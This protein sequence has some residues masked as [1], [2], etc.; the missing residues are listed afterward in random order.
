MITAS[1]F[2]QWCQVFGIPTGGGSGGGVTADQV[3]R[4]AFNYAPSMGV[5][6][7]FVVNLSP[8]VAAL[9]DGL[10]V[11]MSSGSLQNST[12]S[13][14][15]KVNSLPA[16]PITLWAGD[17]APGD[18]E[19][20]GSYLFIYNE[21]ANSFQLIN[22]S[23]TTADAFLVQANA[24]NNAI[25]NG[26]PNA[27]NVTLVL[28]PQGTIGLG[29]SIYMQ[30]GAGNDNTGA[31]TLSVN[32]EVNPIFLQDGSQLTAGA[33]VSNGLA[34]LIYSAELD[35]W[36]LMNPANAGDGYVQSVSGTA[37]Q[38]IIDNTDPQNPVASTPQDID[39]DSDVTFNTLRLDGDGLYDANG[40][41]IF[42]LAPVADAVNSMSVY[43]AATGFPPQMVSAGP[44]VDI[45]MYLVAKGNKPVTVFGGAGGTLPFVILSGTGYQHITNFLFA[46]TAQTRNITFPD[47]S[48][49]VAFTDDIPVPGLTWVPVS[50]T[51]QACAVNTGYISNNAALTTFTAPATAPVGSEIVVKGVGAG[52]WTMTANTGQTIR[53]G[54]VVTS[55]GGTVTSQNGTDSFKM[56][57]IVANTTWSIDYAVSAGLSIV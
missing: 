31:S 52:G 9:T 22:P 3:Q 36:V 5:N 16:L 49:T 32:G 26:A 23:L 25:D 10:I 33:L 35:G 43:N 29:F 38:I 45:A 53:L 13:P 2:I 1:E 30:V 4:F 41:L 6:D 39:T 47:K 12:T 27:Y 44:D 34:Y 17:L 40:K 48:G 46:N 8:P 14:T 57:C 51:S 19:P 50:G 21:D 37:K 11:S 15:L 42:L 54:N 20:G 56:T 28:N 24:Y 7:A 18:I 55:S